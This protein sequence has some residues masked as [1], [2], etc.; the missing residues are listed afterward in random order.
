[1]TKR[2]QVLI[3]GYGKMGHVMEALLQDCHQLAFWDKFP[4]PEL[5]PAPLESA[6]P[7]ADIVLF[8]M[9]VKP[10]REAAQLIAPLL[11]PDCL[12]LSIAKGLD[13]DGKPAAQVFADV[14][15]QAQPYGVLYGPM[16]SAELL[17]GRSGFAQLA[18]TRT[19]YGKVAASLFRDSGLH[20]EQSMDIKGISW[21]AIL[22]NVYA[23][24][25]GMSDE[26]Q[27]GDNVRGL[28]AVTAMQELEQIVCHMGGKSGAAWHLAGL[29]D[30]I[31][32]A[33]SQTSHHH[34]TG[35]RL[36]RGEREDIGGE[37]VNTLAMV[38]KFQLFR[39]A[40]YPLYDLIQRCV[41]EPKELRIQFDIFL[42]QE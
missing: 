8:C 27:L 35:R 14:F 17:D 36:A 13:E 38:Q 20:I 37:G 32:T 18:C 5:T 31:T 23:L 2:Y 9:P 42:Q 25:F 6:A 24:A 29:G 11:K 28:L 26:L 30:L 4:P 22:K 19:E 39:Q 1:M 16:I 41:S 10:H 15:A 12:C 40:D 21:A 33:T 34:N 7:T 3:L